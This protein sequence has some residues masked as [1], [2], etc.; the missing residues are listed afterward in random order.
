VPDSRTK[1][2]VSGVTVEVPPPGAFWPKGLFFTPLSIVKLIVEIIEP[3]QGRI[4]DPAY[5]E[6]YSMAG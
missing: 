1:F 3:F 4:Y 6:P 2:L 5:A